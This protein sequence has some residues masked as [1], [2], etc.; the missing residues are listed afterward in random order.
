MNRIA[1]RVGFGF[2]IAAAYR[3]FFVINTGSSLDLFISAAA[4]VVLQHALD[5]EKS[6]GQPPGEVLP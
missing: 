4:S 1:A 6:T 5:A 3:I 2:P